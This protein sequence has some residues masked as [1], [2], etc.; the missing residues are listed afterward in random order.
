MILHLT[1]WGEKFYKI[2]LGTASS[3][4]KEEEDI[5]AIIIYNNILFC[6]LVSKE[7]LCN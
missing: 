4:G 6:P 5:D 3:L 2:S 7:F 1:S